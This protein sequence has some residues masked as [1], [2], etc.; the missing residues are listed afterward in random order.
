MAQKTSLDVVDILR[1]HL[2][3]TVML[4]TL[5]PN[6]GLYK[7]QRPLNSVKED[8]VVDNIA[9]GRGQ[10]SKGVAIVNIFVQNLELTIAEVVDR[11]QPNYSRLKYLTTLSSNALEEVYGNDYNFE[12]QSDNIYPD[13]NNQHYVNIRVEFTS[14]NI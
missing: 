14:I 7:F 5:K 8:V 3:N 13:T 9:Q 10:V 11:T 2:A 12:V 1:T 4:D 6:G